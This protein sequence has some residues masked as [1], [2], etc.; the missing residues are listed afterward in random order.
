M[1]IVVLFQVNS[2]Y[3]SFDAEL[4]Q[5]IPSASF[6]PVIDGKMDP[7]WYS[8][9]NSIMT[10]PLEKE[11]A[12]DNWFDLWGK[13][14]LMHDDLNLYGFFIIHDDSINST[15]ANSTDQDGIDLFFN[16]D[17][18]Y[19][20]GV[21]D[22]VNDVQ[23]RI[24]TEWL[25]GTDVE[26]YYGNNGFNWGF[27]NSGI[28]F[29]FQQTELGYNLEISI[30]LYA[31]QLDAHY[32]DEIGLEVQINDSDTGVRDSGWRWWSS[33]DSSWFDAS[34]F[35][36]TYWNGYIAS[37]TLRIEPSFSEPVIDGYLDDAWQG[38]PDYSSNT[39]VTH[40][41]YI[42]DEAWNI[43]ERVDDWND[44]DFNFRVMTHDYY[45]YFF[46][47]VRDDM[48]STEAGE[49]WQKDGI[50]LFFDGDNSKNDFTHNGIPYDDN[51]KHLRQ[52]FSD[53]PTDDCAC[54][55]TELG[56]TM[57]WR[58]PLTDLGFDPY[59]NI[60]GFEV[61]L[62]DQDDPALL[63][64]GIARW[65]GNDNNTW[66]DASMFGTAIVVSGYCCGNCWPDVQVCEATDVTSISARINCYVKVVYEGI[67]TGV[68]FQW[69]NNPHYGKE[70]IAANSP[71]INA[72]N[73]EA[74]ADLFDLIP[75]TTY[76]YRVIA[77]WGSYKTYTYG[78]SFTTSPD[79][80]VVQT[81]TATDISPTTAVLH[82]EV[83]AKGIPTTV[84]FQYSESLNYDK[85]YSAVN[86][87]VTDTITTL[88][89][90]N[91]TGLTANTTYHYRVVTSSTAGTAYGRDMT[92]TT[93]ESTDIAASLPVPQQFSLQQNFPNPAN[94]VTNIVYELPVNS[95]V[96]IMIY[97]LQGELVRTLF[98][99]AQGPGRYPL[100]WEGADESGA[101]VASGL[102]FLRMDADGFTDMKKIMLVK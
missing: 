61:Q 99:G 21:Y 40:N 29:A 66:Q 53:T 17:N 89:S 46:A 4:L 67:P 55:R 74:Y 100:L 20:E 72:L 85:Q 54:Q 90:A 1:L 92:F 23:L 78:T 13:F 18:S 96:K 24:N 5:L 41:A 81:Q 88:V 14:K 31:L 75:N 6:A 30:P 63:R 56:W 60:I 7:I 87:T 73:K 45:L 93:L 2:I 97:N 65:W 8:V 37:D 12:P 43:Y 58:I 59:D 49:D 70:I 50:E 48:I 44:M 79:L 69:G 51:D 82:G 57:E 28:V 76:Y 11:A 77:N 71:V 38:I 80:P 25:S 64:S 22:G 86:S 62:N 9:T 33:T 102:Y 91:V 101:Q 52:I 19:T 95:H 26:A 42:P 32:N 83:N 94:P 27:D 36:F 15:N 84:I 35:G 3:A 68:K 39:F 98:T 10:K 47:T 16:S 34:K